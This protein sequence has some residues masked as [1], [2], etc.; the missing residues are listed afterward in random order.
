MTA[1]DPSDLARTAYDRVRH[2]L[3]W[4]LRYHEGRA[5]MNAAEHCE[6]PADRPLLAALRD[7]ASA[8]TAHLRPETLSNLREI[9]AAGPAKTL[10]WREAYEREL[11]RAR[12]L[13]VWHTMLMDLD[14]CEHGRHEGDVCSGCGGPS[15]GNPILIGAHP[16][17]DVFPAIVRQVGYSIDGRPLLVPSR[18]S[19]HNPDAWTS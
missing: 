17:P 18:E 1:T 7:A 6:E 13:D 9:P 4:A 11:V 2:A 14:R 12:S 10:T 3:R 5:E 16:R 8:L 19:K 15:L